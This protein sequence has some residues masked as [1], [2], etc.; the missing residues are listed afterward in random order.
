MTEKHR[1]MQRAHIQG[2]GAEE[3]ERKANKKINVMPMVE[4]WRK[5]VS[6]SKNQETVNKQQK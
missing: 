3:V 2:K 6:T 1:G 4:K 5:C